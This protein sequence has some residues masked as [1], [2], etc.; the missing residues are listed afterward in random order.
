M[1]LVSYTDSSYDFNIHFLMQSFYF[2]YI[3]SFMT[4]PKVK[5]LLYHVSIHVYNHTFLLHAKQ[6]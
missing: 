3:L 4:F 1:S 6:F 5:E 2:L